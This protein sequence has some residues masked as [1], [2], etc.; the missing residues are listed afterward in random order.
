M[1][2]RERDCIID[3]SPN[4]ADARLWTGTGYDS[5]MSSGQARPAQF[6]ILWQFWCWD[7]LGDQG[8]TGE[9]ASIDGRYVK[10]KKTAPKAGIAQM[11]PGL[12]NMHTSIYNRP[13]PAG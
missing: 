2:G 10:K 9:T 5:I 7:S 13:K 4:V 6:I 1:R 11:Q 8:T 12:L 3:S